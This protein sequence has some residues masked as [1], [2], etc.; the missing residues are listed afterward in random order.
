MIATSR[1]SGSSPAIS[2]RYEFSRLQD[3]ALASAYAA[4]IPVATRLPERLPHRRDDRDG[5][6]SESRSP[7]RSAA[8]A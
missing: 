6:T 8:G 1:R 4:L 5:S 7:Q 2:R 3:Q